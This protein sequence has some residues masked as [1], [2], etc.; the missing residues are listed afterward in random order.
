MARELTYDLNDPRYTIYHRAAL[1]G[2]AATV[3]AWQIRGTTPPGIRATLACDRVTLTWGDELTDREA[4]RRILDASF[5]IEGDLI[6]LPGQAPRGMGADLRLAL[7]NGYC[8]TFLQ[9]NKMRPAPAG[10]KGAK[11]ISL[12]LPDSE[13]VEVFT[14]KPVASYAHQ[15]AQGTRLL[16]SDRFPDAVPISQAIVPGALSGAEAIEVPPED[17]VLL[18]FLMVGTSVFLVRSHSRRE[19]AQYCLVVP[20]VADLERFARNLAAIAELSTTFRALTRTYLGHVAGGAEEAALKFLLD[21]FV[22]DGLQAQPAVRGCLAV[23]MGKVAWDA[24]QINRSAIV[25][26][27]GDYDEREVF[28]AAAEAGKARVIQTKKGESFA[29]PASA[30]PE[31]VAANLA[32]GDHW[33]RYFRDLVG[34]KKESQRMQ[35]LHGGLVKMKQAIRDAD[36]QLVIDV[37]HEAWKRT[38]KSI[39]EDAKSGGVDPARAKV[40]GDRR[41]EVRRER[42]RNE[43]L[44][45]KTQDQLAGWFL[46]FSARAIKGNALSPLRNDGNARRFRNFLFDRRNFERFQNLCLFALL[47]YAG[48]PAEQGE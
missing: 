37:F 16:D 20:D 46:D 32:A 27:S 18:L 21:L 40:I 39:Y 10:M 25:P 31:I 23:A 41:V 6:D 30:L 4:L 19:K 9:H 26:I 3:R 36:D 45:S 48:T 11:A 33:C 17:G 7:H 42:V 24:N 8:G 15:K 35:F 29:V 13:A 1:G 12:R 38:M 47:S 43:I 34:K 5:L 22:A 28:A 2:L 44:R 14:Y